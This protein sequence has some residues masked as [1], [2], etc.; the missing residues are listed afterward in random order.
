MQFYK[1]T[2]TK[3]CLA[4]ILCA[5]AILAGCVDNYPTVASPAL[6]YP[7]P[8]DLYAVQYQVGAGNWITAKV[9]VSYY[10]ATAASPWRRDS[11]YT[12]QPIP[13]PLTGAGVT[14]MSFVSIPAQAGVFVRL[15]VAKLFGTPF[16]ATDHVFARPSTK[17][18]AVDTERDGTVLIS[19]FTAPD[20][21]GEQ[22]ILWW[23]RQADSAA[24]EGLAFFLNPPYTPP[25]APHKV[26]V[27]TPQTDLTDPS[28]LLGYD[29]LDFEGKI[30]LGPGGAVAYQVPD[31]I[32]TIFFGPDAW[33]Q[34]KLRFSA[35]GVT[36]TIYGP[37]VLDVSRFNYVNRLCGGDDGYFA[38]SSETGTK[39]DGF[40]IDGIIVTDHNHAATDA[41]QNSTL[42]NVKTIG[43]NGENAALRFDDT[44]T[45]SNLF[46]RSGDDS[47]MVWGKYVTITNATV[48]QNYNGGVVS[49]GWLN[50]SYGTGNS[51]DGLWVVKT[52]WTK[53]INPSFYSSSQVG[54]PS[55]L[56]YQ[57]NGVFVSLMVPS[58]AYGA[59]KPPTFRNIFVEDAPQVLF[60]L[61]IV[62]TM[63]CSG[64][65]CTAASMLPSS[66]IKLTIEN[67][68]SPQSL[69]SN[70]IGFQT[71]NPRYTTA[72][73]DVFSSAY[74]LT[75]TMDITLNN[76]FI[77]LPGGFIVPLTAF[78]ALNEGL[79]NTHG[80]GVNIKYGL[81][82]P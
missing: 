6:D 76:V 22:F 14:S 75:G 43:W 48:W 64:Y 66:S 25:T 56:A 77:K 12:G 52:D 58:T 10:G 4:Q 24:V 9:Y 50:N 38:L 62:P 23:N 44:C 5:G 42:N 16:Q 39:L 15:R 55:P 30:R 11:G 33:V 19:T 81:E 35:T 46:V 60:S 53:P 29:T 65:F 74:T 7:R 80:D 78:D 3:L 69:A 31:S 2:M 63:N 57:N 54:P 61:K 18:I 40:V 1:K 36:R 21:N 27:V 70:S 45:G 13:T 41:F 26:K 20:F 59:S 79:I 82:F 28:Q 37:G 8:S 73:G 17:P 49:L 32:T 68:Y 51:I 71:L 47:L 34:G 67:L 72:S